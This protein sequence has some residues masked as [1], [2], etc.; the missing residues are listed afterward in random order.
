MNA[1]APIKVVPNSSALSETVGGLLGRDATATRI[2][3]S[4]AFSAANRNTY[5]ALYATANGEASAAVQCDIRFAAGAATALAMMSVDR[6]AEWIAAR[7]LPEDGYGNL[8]EIFNVLAAAFNDVTPDRHVKLVEVLSPG[9]PAPREYAALF[10]GRAARV[11]FTV[12]I[13]EYCSGRIVLLNA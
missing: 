9:T 1:L 8:H 12:D 2:G 11:D 10:N 13:A 4:I 5:L 7:I 3:P 6:T